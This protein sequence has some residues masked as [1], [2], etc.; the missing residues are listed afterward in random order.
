MEESV[1]FLCPLNNIR[2]VE[3]PSNV[4]FIKPGDINVIGALGDSLTAGNGNFALN[5][6]H[7]YIENRGIS[8]TIGKS[9]L[10]FII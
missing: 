6:L 8:A 5:R 2:S 1:P 3:K 10:Y 7:V 9:N 4:H